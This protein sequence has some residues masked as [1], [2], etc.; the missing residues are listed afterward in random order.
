MTLKQ[1]KEIIEDFL[2]EKGIEENEAYTLSKE[3]LRLLLIDFAIAMEEKN[4]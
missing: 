4:G 1:V 3:T 2:T